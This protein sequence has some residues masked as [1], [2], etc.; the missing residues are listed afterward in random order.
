MATRHPKGG[1]QIAKWLSLAVTAGLAVAGVLYAVR[2]AHQFAALGRLSVAQFATISV[3]TFASLLLLGW[4]NKLV[5][6]TFGVELRFREWFGLTM[7]GAMVNMFAPFAPGAGMRGL[8]LK[9]VHGLPYLH[10]ANCLAAPLLIGM[11]ANS[12]LAMLA[13]VFLWTVHRSVNGLLFAVVLAAFAIPLALVLRPMSLND[14][15]HKWGR[16]LAMLVNGWRMIAV[17]RSIVIQVGATMAARTLLL[18]GVYAVIL[19][20]IDMQIPLLACLTMASLGSIVRL[21][22][23]TPGALGIYE[24][25]LMMI[26]TTFGIPPSA[27]MMVG[28]VHRAA[29]SVLIL[30]SGAV[31]GHVLG[32]QLSSA[33]YQEDSSGR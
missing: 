16:R 4:S 3:V 13:L 9:R 15:D 17:D 24:G 2:H 6:Q 14:S 5:V 30:V 27:G 31:S 32:L 26:S 25:V 12:G 19:A 20:G 21:I 10:F 11:M 22:N 29:S 18:T 33:N 23:V 8:Y 7:V 28:L 1:S